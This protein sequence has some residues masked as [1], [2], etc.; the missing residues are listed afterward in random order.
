MTG[1]ERAEA[2]LYLGE[3][4]NVWKAGME[5]T[6]PVTDALS[7]FWSFCVAHFNSQLSPI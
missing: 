3:H 7:A 1:E 6:S 5:V 4:V 2:R